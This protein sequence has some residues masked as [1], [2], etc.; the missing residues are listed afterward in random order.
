MIRLNLSATRRETKRIVLA[1][2]QRKMTIGQ[3]VRSALYQILGQRKHR[4]QSATSERPA[5]RRAKL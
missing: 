4:S 1:A 5:R 2:N 3:F